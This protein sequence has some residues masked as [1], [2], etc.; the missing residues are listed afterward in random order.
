MVFQYNR[1]HALQAAKA[2]IET[3]Q[4]SQEQGA[5]L[6][7]LGL[8]I[9]NGDEFL[10][11]YAHL[12]PENDT[13]VFEP[14]LDIPFTSDTVRSNV[15]L[16]TILQELDALFPIGRHVSFR[17]L[18]FV[19]D[20]QFMIDWW[21]EGFKI[22]AQYEDN[23]NLSWTFTYAVISASMMRAAEAA[24]DPYGLDASNGPLIRV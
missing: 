13:D 6:D 17:T 11:N 7:T 1:S 3:N 22:F 21:Q 23:S 10:M 5:G 14:A 19:P 4:R 24:N 9:G 16:K 18:A 15:T 2:L 12:K 8:F 20:A